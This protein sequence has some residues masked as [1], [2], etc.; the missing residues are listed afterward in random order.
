MSPVGPEGEASSPDGA[1]RNP[2]PRVRRCNWGSTLPLVPA[3]AGTHA[4]CPLVIAPPESHRS[5]REYGSPPAKAGTQ[6]QHVRT[7]HLALDSRLRGNERRVER[8]SS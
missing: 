6:G 5:F 1:Y 3:Q 2:G 7:S 8:A 4:P